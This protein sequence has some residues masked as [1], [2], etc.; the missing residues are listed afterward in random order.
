M[1]DLSYSFIICSSL[2]LL[3]LSVAL[4][5]SGVSMGCSKRVEDARRGG[6]VIHPQ[7]RNFGCGYETT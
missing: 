3:S 4:I 6:D 5:Q 1:L 2:L 7:L